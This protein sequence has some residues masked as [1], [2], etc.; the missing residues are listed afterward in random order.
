MEQLP[1][2]LGF[3]ASHLTIEQTGLGA[4]G[5]FCL[6]QGQ[7]PPLLKPI[8]LE[9]PANGRVGRD[10]LQ[11]ALRFRQG[12]QIVSM[13]LD[14]PTFVRS[15]LGVQRLAHRIAHCDLETCVAAHLAPQGP[16]WIVP[17]PE[18]LIVPAFYRREAEADRC[19]GDWVTPF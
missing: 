17:L 7:S 3:I 10:R 8:G 1:D 18:A 15:V 14:R 16:Y 12:K 9:E 19:A 5:T 4:L 6:S 11:F 13:K 2:I